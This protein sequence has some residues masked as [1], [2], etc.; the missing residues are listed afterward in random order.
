MKD[1][2]IEWTGNTWN[3]WF[4]CDA[5]SEG[6]LHCYAATWAAR[7]G[8]QFWGNV[9]RSKTTFEDPL[10]WEASELIFTCSLGDFFHAKA[11]GWRAEAWDIIRRTRRHRYQILTKRPGLIRSRLPEDWASG[12]FEHVWLG[13]S[14]EVP[15]YAFRLNSLLQV[16]EGGAGLFVSCEPLLGPVNVEPWLC[17][18]SWA[19]PLDWVIVGGESGPGARPMTERWAVD[20]IE[21][22]DQVRVPVTVKQ[23]GKVLGNELGCSDQKGADRS[24]WPDDLRR[25]EHPDWFDEVGLR[26]EGELPPDHFVRK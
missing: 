24:A 8:R 2:N 26:V 10:K 19:R 1:S 3:P 12:A 18:E 4:G 5:V 13:T 7:T 11:D 17:S 16:P 14:V 9:K 21:Q 22:C 20:L 15:E 6:C 23:L 25:S